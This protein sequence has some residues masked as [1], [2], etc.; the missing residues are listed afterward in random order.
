MFF[1]VKFESMEEYRGGRGWR[2]RNAEELLFDLNF[3]LTFAV[4]FG[5]RN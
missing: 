5:F 3:F 4:G 1:W 2:G